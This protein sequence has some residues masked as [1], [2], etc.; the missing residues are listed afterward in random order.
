MMITNYN[1]VFQDVKNM[2]DILEVAT[3]YGVEVTTKNKAICPFHDDHHPSLSFKNN[4]F[5]CFVCG[6]SG[7]VIDFVGNMFDLSVLNAAKK[8]N[9]D[10]NLSV[11]EPL[12]QYNNNELKECVKQRQE[13]DK[14][15]QSFEIWK[16]VTEK[17]FLKIF[18]LF[19][20]IQKDFAP[21]N[22]QYPHKLW[23][24]A[25]NNI[26]YVEQILELFASNSRE[27]ILDEYS[28]VKN[29]Q[30]KIINMLEEL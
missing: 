24:I 12:N 11:F 16:E 17:W 4:K 25:L 14:I 13:I 15:I 26:E 9:E 6:V 1:N 29:Y 3:Y 10:F 8:L 19:R 7:S 2:L 23:F 21:K 20:V 5:K 28:N 18:K 27:Q 30:L 22:F